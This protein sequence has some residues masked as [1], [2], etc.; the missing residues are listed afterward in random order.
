MRWI[1]VMDN[2]DG[3]REGNGGARERLRSDECILKCAKIHCLHVLLLFIEFV[4]DGPPKKNVYHF[5]SGRCR[6]E[7]FRILCVR[8]SS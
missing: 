6:R 3:E 5:G 8:V 1:S 2:V 4:C 7:K